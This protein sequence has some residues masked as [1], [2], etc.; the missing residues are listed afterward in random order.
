MLLV[1]MSKPYTFHIKKLKLEWI[2]KYVDSLIKSNNTL[3]VGVLLF[4]CEMDYSCVRSLLRTEIDHA[5]SVE[6]VEVFPLMFGNSSSS[7]IGSKVIENVTYGVIFG[8]FS[9][10]KSP[11]LSL[12]N[13]ISQLIYV[14]DSVC[15]PG[16][17]VLMLADPDLTL[18]KVHDENLSWYTKYIGSHQ[19]IEKFQRDLAKDKLPVSSDIYN[20]D[21][22]EE[23][24]SFDDNCTNENT[25]SFHRE[26][27]ILECSYGQYGDESV[28]STSSTPSKTPLKV[29]VYNVIASVKPRKLVLFH[30]QG[31][32]PDV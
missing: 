29:P 17:N 4:S 7:V 18:F 8:K 19:A 11:L 28:A 13:D 23:D 16:C 3:Q 6:T 26:E 25:S 2:R 14:V 22:G 30:D 9:V 15:P 31:I 12:Y 1:G 10:I 20:S 5:S 24:A 32:L 27:S 21:D